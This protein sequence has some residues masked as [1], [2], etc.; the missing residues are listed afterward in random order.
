MHCG[1]IMRH[2]WEQ[3]V[4]NIKERE[5]ELT[6]VALLARLDI[7]RHIWLSECRP[8]LAVFAQQP[9]CGRK[10][11][12]ATRDAATAAPELLKQTCGRLRSTNRRIPYSKD[13]ENLVIPSRETLTGNKEILRFTCEKVPLS[14]FILPPIQDGYSSLINSEIVERHYFCSW[15]WLSLTRKDVHYHIQC[16]SEMYV[17]VD[18][19]ETLV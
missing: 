11:I 6:S 3:A 4:N 9:T 14:I 8:D 19:H 1:C 17:I 18:I 16:M 13:N 2:A 12:C 7:D 5:K 15:V 10:V